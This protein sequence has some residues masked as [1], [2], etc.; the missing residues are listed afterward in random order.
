M[1]HYI[2][3]RDLIGMSVMI[4]SISN[5]SNGLIIRGVVE[6]SHIWHLKGERIIHQFMP[7]TEAANRLKTIELPAKVGFIKRGKKLDFVLYN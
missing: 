5:C 2:K 3:T 4:N 1:V 7:S 6:Y